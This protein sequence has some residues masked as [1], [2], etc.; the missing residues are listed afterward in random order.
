MTIPYSPPCAPGYVLKEADAHEMIRV[1]RGVAEGEA[2][3]GPE[4]ARKLSGFFSTPTASKE[5]FPELTPREGEVL[6]MIA[7]RLYVS[8]SP[9]ATMSRTSF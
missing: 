1:I 5:V 9:C 4:I 8:P 3:F 2:Y 6:D 7:R